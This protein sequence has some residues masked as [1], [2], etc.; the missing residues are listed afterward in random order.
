MTSGNATGF[1]VIM[2]LT[3]IGIPILAALNGGLGARY[4]F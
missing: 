1:A 2:L 3:G 4:Y